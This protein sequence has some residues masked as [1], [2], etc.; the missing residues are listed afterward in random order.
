MGL[1]LAIAG[2]SLIHLFTMIM[3]LDRLGDIERALRFMGDDIH[4]RGR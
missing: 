2:L 4:G 1:I 3:L